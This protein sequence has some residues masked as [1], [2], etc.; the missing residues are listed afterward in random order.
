MQSR[1]HSRAPTRR[2]ATDD[3]TKQSKDNTSTSLSSISKT[4]GLPISNEYGESMGSTR[5]C[6]EM[7][8]GI[9]RF[10]STSRQGE[11]GQV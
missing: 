10:Q 7:P 2:I 1:A 3:A 8:S 6:D 5:Q 9:I 4:A 11:T